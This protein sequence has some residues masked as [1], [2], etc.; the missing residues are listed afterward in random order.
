MPRG[1]KSYTLDEKIEMT[2]NAIETKTEE[3]S[4]LKSTL[5]DLKRQK[6]QEDL[7]ALNELIK[8]SGKSIEEV[9][10]ILENS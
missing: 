2:E 10:S 3:L 1:R 4:E 5:K 9:K 6:E 8:S 7:S